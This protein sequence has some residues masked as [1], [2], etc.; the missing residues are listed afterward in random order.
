MGMKWQMA[1]VL[2]GLVSVPVLAAN[3]YKWVDAQ[4]HFHFSDTAEPGWRRV[5]VSPTVVDG[6]PLPQTAAAT[7]S[8]K[9]AAE[10]RQKR[11]ALVGYKTAARIVERNG[12]GVEHEYTAEE[13]QKL[14]AMTEQQLA[15]CPPAD[16]PASDDAGDN[17]D[18]GDSGDSGSDETG[19]FPQ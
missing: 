19:E 5:D 18:A 12:L 11:D 6:G 17:A 4:G 9:R 1:A 8:D 7:A 2:A 13:K 14:I 10:C 3:V 16:A 15:S